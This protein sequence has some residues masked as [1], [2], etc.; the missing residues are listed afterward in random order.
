M[1]FL[2]L[3]FHSVESERLQSA[4]IFCSKKIICSNSGSM[5]FRVVFLFLFYFIC[6]DFHSFAIQPGAEVP[7]APEVSD[8]GPL[9]AQK[10]QKPLVPSILESRAVVQRSRFGLFAQIG[11]GIFARES[12]IT[13]SLYIA[14]VLFFT[15]GL[16]GYLLDQCQWKQAGSCVQLIVNVQFA[17]ET[18]F[19]SASQITM[20]GG[21]ASLEPRFYFA[22]QKRI[23]WTLQAGL[24]YGYMLGSKTVGYRGGIWGIVGTG[25]FVSF[26]SGA[27]LSLEVNYSPD[28]NNYH[29]VYVPLGVH[30]R[31]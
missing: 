19:Q 6:L 12:A 21:L 31:F 13:P 11:P 10:I 27:G 1:T 15:G 29:S 16:S 20:V 22:G 9:P 7:K 23:A 14:P 18:I 4:K 24:G 25:I 2:E 3:N 30:Y 8:R 26:L 5:R 28:V 17:M